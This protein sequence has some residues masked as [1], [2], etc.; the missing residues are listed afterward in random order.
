MT[1]EPEPSGRRG[2]LHG[3]IAAAVTP[4][5]R[6]GAELDLGAVGPLVELY[7]QAGLTGVMIGGT[8]GEGMLLTVDERCWLTD[9]FIAAAA[10]RIDIVVHSGAQSTR[11][12][13]SIAEHAAASKATAVSVIAPPYFRLDA[14]AIL[15]HMATAANA[16]APTPFYIYE[17]ADR[18]GY[19]VPPEVLRALDE[20]SE[21]FVGLK[22]SDAPLE[23]FEKYLLPWLDILVGPEALVAV[24]YAR[25]AVGAVSALAAAFPEFVAA[26]VASHDEAASESA[27]QLRREMERQP[28]HA[29]LKC[30][31]RH[32]GIPITEAVR[33]PLRALSPA[34][35]SSLLTRMDGLPT[36]TELAMPP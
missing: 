35:R 36:G 20:R 7:I 27:A 34:E 19:P 1:T 16:C 11:D 33:A 17:F 12:T 9:A 5:S 28:L 10:G 8:T 25:G 21:T 4:L 2:P 26:A 24:G 30:V 6:D 32:R 14:A 18:S 3:A 13:V 23:R 31:L 22:V 15:E 29:A